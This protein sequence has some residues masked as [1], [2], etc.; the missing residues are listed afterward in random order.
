MSERAG[1]VECTGEEER[2]RESDLNT[3]GPKTV[4]TSSTGQ[5]GQAQTEWKNFGFSDLSCE[6]N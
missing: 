3:V 6:L 5:T 2:E 1:E 4:E